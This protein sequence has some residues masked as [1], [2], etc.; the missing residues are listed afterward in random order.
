MERQV[1]YAYPTSA[2]LAWDNVWENMILSDLQ[3]SA[4]FFDGADPMIETEGLGESWMNMQEWADLSLQPEIIDTATLQDIENETETAGG[5][6][7]CC[8]GMVSN[9]SSSNCQRRITKAIG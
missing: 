3:P 6:R 1:N 8:Y 2:T 5:I 7:F 9:P 4:T